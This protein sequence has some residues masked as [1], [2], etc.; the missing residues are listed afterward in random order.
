L[1]FTQVQEF[2]DTFGVKTRVTTSAPEDL[3]AAVRVR[4]AKLRFEL[5]R[6]EFEELNKAFKEVDIVELADALG[7]IR[8]VVIGAAQVFGLT[9]QTNSHY[10]TNSESYGE[11]LLNEDVQKEILQL[12]RLAILRDQSVDVAIVLATMLRLVD[13]AAEFLRIDLDP[14][15]TAIHESNM[16][17]LAAD[18]T[19]IR[20]EG[21]NKVLKGENFKTPTADIERLLGFD[22]VVAE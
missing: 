7:D 1:S 11:Q 10:K 3:N 4:E 21:D 13:D 12:L 9:H 16:S 22:D 6:E 17:K 18:G 14:I 2:N 15:A 19:V 5:I 8:Y 20:R